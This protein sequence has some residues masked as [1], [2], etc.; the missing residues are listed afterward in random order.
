MVMNTCKDCKNCFLFEK[1]K[2]E[3]QRHYLYIYHCKAG[4]RG[5]VGWQNVTAK[6]RVIRENFLGSCYNF[7]WKEIED[8]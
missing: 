7:Q 5:E 8:E 2:V 4:I 3:G 6:G 1:K